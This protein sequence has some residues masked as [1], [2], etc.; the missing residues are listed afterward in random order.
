MEDLK[1]YEC[2]DGLIL[3]CVRNINI[4]SFIKYLEDKKQEGYTTISY[5]ENNFWGHTNPC[6][7]FDK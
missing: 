1:K 7:D 5:D 2:E 3:A 6:L 4:N